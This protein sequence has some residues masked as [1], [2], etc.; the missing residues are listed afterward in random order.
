MPLAS[1]ASNSAPDWVKAAAQQTIPE[2]PESTKAV[3]LLDE[4]TYTVDQKGQA[5]EHVRRVTKIL[6][7]QGREYGEPMVYFDKDSK[8]LS[9]HV[10]SIDPGGKEY[11]LKDNEIIDFGVPGGNGELYNDERFRVAEP[12]GRDPGGIVAI[13]Y[14]RRERPYLAEAIWDFQTEV[15]H[16]TQSF[17]LRTPSRSPR[18]KSS[19]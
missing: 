8:V 7:P 15:P 4:T 18:Q 10:W 17:T 12:P 1:H 11:A 2:L 13:E 3:V 9:M 14:E 6:R 19:P 16:L 5:V